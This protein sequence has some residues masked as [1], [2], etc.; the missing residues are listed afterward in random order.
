MINFHS[1]PSLI[2][3]NSTVRTILSECKNILYQ[4]K[5]SW[6]RKNIKIIKKLFYKWHLVK[7]NGNPTKILIC[8][9]IK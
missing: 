7:I 9:I 2:W 1:W 4:N 5:T 8:K 6:F 3:L